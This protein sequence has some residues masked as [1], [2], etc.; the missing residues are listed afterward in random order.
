V[1]FSPLIGLDLKAFSL[2]SAGIGRY[3]INL[4]KQLLI[5][6]RFSYQGFAS[7]KT[8]L[9]CLSNTDMQLE[10]GISTKI[11]ST[12]LRSLF[13]LP[14]AV[15]NS[16]IDLLHSMDNSTI[17]F[18]FKPPCKRVVTIHDLI[19]FKY[20]EF[21][22]RKHVAVVRNM[23]QI[24][25][26]SADHIIT[27]SN[28]SK[29]DILETFP[30]VDP[31]AITAIPL[32]VASDFIPADDLKTEDFFKKYQLPNRFFLSLGTLEPRKNL[33]RLIEAFCLFKQNSAYANI[34]L[35]LVGAKGWLEAN[36][37]LDYDKMRQFNIQHLGFVEQ[38]YLPLLYSKALAFVYP[39]LY[40]GFGLPILEAMSYG[41]A[42][43]T[44]Y[45]SSL[46]EVAGKAALYV[47]PLSQASIK[48]ALCRLVDEEDLRNR[49]S[50]IALQ[51]SNQ[52]SWDKT[53]AQTE[54]VYENLVGGN[55][56]K[57]S[58]EENQGDIKRSNFIVKC[59]NLKKQ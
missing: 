41:K 35:V 16:K 26:N 33:K 39:S 20:P 4:V 3:T 9:S 46:P 11:H 23:T 43:I 37:G 10:K 22:T 17:K 2:Q 13:F 49:L 53:A 31:D 12:V 42:I 38:R 21:F 25:A 48:K 55:K 40:E 59:Q 18:L 54:K 7:P 44:S 27:D 29:K 32:A 19:V 51:E 36:V 30:S 34:G 58:L 28:A 50:L 47:D 8:D 52:Y 6:E 1:T 24:A 45:S 57:P 5:R 56:Y 15:R 14:Q